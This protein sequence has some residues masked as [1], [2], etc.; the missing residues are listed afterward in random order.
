MPNEDFNTVFI[1]GGLITPR[2]ATLWKV[3]QAK[4]KMGTFPFSSSNLLLVQMG[5]QSSLQVCV[6]RRIHGGSE[7][8]TNTGQLMNGDAIPLKRERWCP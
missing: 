4:A 1:L 3:L 6:S 7:H 8:F 2:N 5:L